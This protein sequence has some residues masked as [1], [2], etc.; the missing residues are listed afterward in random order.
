MNI[1]KIDNTKIEMS[2]VY[3]YPCGYI[4]I[5]YTYIYIYFIYVY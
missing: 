4:C 5:L 2:I 3:L 1:F